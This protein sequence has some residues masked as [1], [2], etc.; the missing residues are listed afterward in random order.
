[1]LKADLH[2]HAGEDAV[3]NIS[4]SAIQLIDEA[5]RRKFDVLSFTFH[6]RV[7]FPE[8]V[9]KYAK[10]QGIL[11]IPGCEMS[12]QNRHVLIYNKDP[13]KLRKIVKQIQDADKVSSIQ[14]YKQDSLVIAPH[15]YYINPV[16]PWKSHCLQGLLDHNIEV[17][18]AIEFSHFYYYK[19]SFN[20]KAVE[21]ARKHKKALIGTSDL[22][23]MYN[24]DYTY[25]LIDS[26]KSIEKIFQAIRKGKVKLAT[27]SLPIGVFIRL[28]FLNAIHQ[29]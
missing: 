16:L 21:M 9:K 1:M 10:K 25:S 6:Y 13:I 18:D 24:F 5:K 11:L 15:P 23:R 17:F 4:Y 12:V 7:F 29:T 14:K 20:Y 8:H 26:E 27:R 2:L 19:I 22:H 3:D 28:G